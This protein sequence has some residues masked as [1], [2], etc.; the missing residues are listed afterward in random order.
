[1]QNDSCFWFWNDEAS[2]L[3]ASMQS[4]SCVLKEKTSLVCCILVPLVWLKQPALKGNYYCHCQW[5]RGVHAASAA[6][7]VINNSTFRCKKKKKQGKFYFVKTKRRRDWLAKETSPPSSCSV[8]VSR[9]DLLIL[10][11]ATLVHRGCLTLPQ[12]QTGLSFI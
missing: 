11:A 12:P 6:H 5:S 4:Q 9:C 10:V 7:I 3:F 8:G 2:S 1:M